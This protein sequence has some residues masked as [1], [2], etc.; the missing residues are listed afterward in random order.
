MTVLISYQGGTAGDMLTASLNNIELNF[1]QSNF[2]RVKDFSLKD[3]KFK[4]VADL[5]KIVAEK[6]QEYLSTHEFKLL[7][8]SGLR[9]INIEVTDPTTKELCILRQMKIQR[10]NIAVDPNSHW[11]QIVKTLCNK[12]KYLDAADYWFSR[13]RNL[14]LTEMDHRIITN[15]PKRINFNK[16]FSDDFYNSIVQ[17]GYDIPALKDNHA[18]WLQKNLA[19]SW[20]KESTLDSIADKL[21]QMDWARTSG[22]V[23]YNGS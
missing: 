12:A 8:D 5:H 13:A 21:S 6:S 20:S 4:T 17:Q 1:D 18:K 19:D 11:F 22:I 7:F 14:W 23:T 10:L 15:V 3:I 16:L 9:W 2:V